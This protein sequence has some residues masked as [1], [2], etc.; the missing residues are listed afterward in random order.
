MLLEE[1]L[2][3][4]VEIVNIKK[5]VTV[6]ELMEQ[7][8]VSE[9]TIRRNLSILDDM[10]KITKVFGGAIAN[11]IT[12]RT[13]DDNVEERKNSHREDKISIARY[14]ASLI[15]SDDF[16]YMDAGTTVECMIPFIP[17]CG[18]KFVT[19]GFSH[20]KELSKVGFQTHLIGGE[21]KLSTESIIGSEAIRALSKY[22]FTKGFFGVNGISHE[23]GCSTPDIREAMVKKMAI[24]QSLKKYV[25]ADNSKFSQLSCVTFASFS[26][27]TII[28]TNLKDKVF[29]SAENII[30][31]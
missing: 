6:Q 12:Y 22:N 15:N 25:L 23:R 29:I 2:G 16:I 20:A 31:I 18:A 17:H 26:E 13:K 3:K 11:N 8:Q 9:S 19:N 5:T 1:R 30:N 10:G 14:A 4:I 28:T 24:E 27:V 21:I 7:L